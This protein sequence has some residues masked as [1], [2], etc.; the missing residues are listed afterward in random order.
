MADFNLE[1]FDKKY[2]ELTLKTEWLSL[3]LK[4]GMKEINDE[5]FKEELIQL[6]VDENDVIDYL[7]FL[8]DFNDT[9]VD[10]A[11]ESKIV[12]MFAIH[13]K[14]EEL[15][16]NTNEIKEKIKNDEID[17]AREFLQNKFEMESSDIEI[18]ISHLK[19]DLK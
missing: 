12:E 5:I 17:L 19:H 18:V 13:I 11:E 4:R 10:I 15:K 1:Y 14:Y 6:G 8:N 2:H 16:N 3:H 7:A 9:I